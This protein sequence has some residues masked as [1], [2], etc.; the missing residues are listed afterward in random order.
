MAPAQSIASRVNAGVDA[1][2]RWLPSWSPGRHRARPRVCRRCT[3]SP[4]LAAAGLAADVPHQVAHALSSRMHRIVERAVDEFT[5]RELPVLH[6]ELAGERLWNAGGFDPGEGLDPE[7]DGV[8]L[9][10][11]PH[12]AGQP[13]LFTLAELAE[14]TRPESPLPRPPLRAE[15]KRQLQA[16]MELADQC[17]SDAGREVCFALA[18]HRPRIRSA[19]ER[20]VEPQIVAILDELSRQL[21]RPRDR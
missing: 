9:D 17:A 6:A 5:L 4:V 2:L 7:F 19:V 14:S 13:F 20:F 16:E 21:E 1:W 11:E 10:P 12:D 8:D 15:E 18:E 3:G